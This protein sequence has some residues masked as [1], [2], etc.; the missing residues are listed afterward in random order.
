MRGLRVPSSL[1]RGANGILPAARSQTQAPL[2][3]RLTT[4][5]N[6][7]PQTTTTT[8]SSPLA[9]RPFSHSAPLRKKKKAP[10]YPTHDSPEI[11]SRTSHTV[12]EADHDDLPG[13]KHPRPD[14]SDPLN[15]ADVASRFSSLAAHH[16]EILKK[17]QSGDRFSPDAIGAL[18]V[19]PDRKDPTTYPLRELA[20]IVPRPGG[21]TVSLL[22]HEK[23]Y[24]KPV[25]AAVQAS[26]DFNQQPQ[27][28]PDNELELILKVEA[29]NK[30]AV[31]RRAKDAAQAWRDKMRT[32]TEKRKKVHA[33]WQKEADIVPDLKRRADKEL[34]KLQDKEMKVV[35]AAEQ[36]AVRKIQG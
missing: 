1:L 29:T 26:A 36:Q 32:V 23:D 16:A 30:D 11:V 5:S 6:A 9:A 7:R 2:A 12:D 19:Q 10:Q 24:V 17:L 4:A 22:L 28:D 20:E 14:P 21:R 15:F 13:S 8:T 25:M 33:K 35:D 18:A 27:R 34:Q 31:V 3:A